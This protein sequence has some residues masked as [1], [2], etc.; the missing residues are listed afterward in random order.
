MKRK[1]LEY[2]NSI[3]DF[4]NTIND[5]EKFV[6][7]NGEEKLRMSNMIDNLNNKIIKL[8]SKKNK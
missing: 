1:S 3:N 6:K 7:D 8:K 5:Y 4:I 2:E